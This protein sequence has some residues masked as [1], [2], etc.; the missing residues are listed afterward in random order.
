M[1]SKPTF[2]IIPGY[3]EQSNTSR[4]RFLKTLLEKKGF[5]VHT[6]R[7]TWKYRV[8]SDYIEEF[9]TFFEK[10][11]GKDNYV[12]GFSFGAMIAFLSAKELSPKH[13]FLCSLSPYFKEDLPKIKSSWKVGMGKRRCK[14][15]EKYSAINIAQEIHT[16]TTIFLGGKEAE[17]T[18]ILEE[19]CKE[20]NKNMSRSRLVVIPDAPHD[21]NYVLYKKALSKEL[22]VF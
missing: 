10:N 11:K 8:M 21:I 16:P 6:P 2:F 22:E 14:D 19:R 20:V 15:F 12:L 1:K 9:K 3:G 7:I 5:K 17:E 4:Y 18:P 13:L